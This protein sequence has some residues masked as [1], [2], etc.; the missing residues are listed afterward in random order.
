MPFRLAQPQRRSSSSLQKISPLFFLFTLIHFVFLLVWI[1]SSWTQVI[2]TEYSRWASLVFCSRN[3]PISTG[4]T[5]S[6]RSPHFL[7]KQLQQF[8]I[9]LFCRT[10]KRISTL[11]LCKLL[12]FNALTPVPGWITLYYLLLSFISFLLIQSWEVTFIQY[13]TL[14]WHYLEIYI[15]N[16]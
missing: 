13:P 1:F 14:C 12:V 2:K 11:V 3:R 5:I 4:V 8:I 9:L 10:A 16:R 15:V 6:T 7:A